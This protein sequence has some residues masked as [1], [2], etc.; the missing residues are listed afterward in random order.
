[1]TR[2]S[3]QNGCFFASAFSR[4]T[5]FSSG[6][7]NGYFYVI[8]WLRCVL[9]ASPWFLLYAPFMVLGTLTFLVSLLT[10]GYGAG[11][12]IAEH[13]TIVQAGG[14][15]YPSVDVFLPTCG[16][17][18][19]LLRNT[20]THVA[21]LRAAYR[22]RLT[23]Y[24]LDDGGRPELKAL[25]SGSGSRT[26]PGPTAGWFKKSGNLKYGFEISDGEFILLLDADF[27]PRTDLLDRDTALLRRVPRSRDRADAAVLP[28]GR[29]ADLGR[30]R[31]G[32]H[33]GAVLPVDP[34]GPGPQGRRD[35]RRKLRRLPPVRARARTA[36]CRSPSTRRT[37]TPASTCTGW[38][39]GCATCRSRCRPGTARTT[40][41]RS[42]TSSTAGARAR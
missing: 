22:G 21:A 7:G 9:L 3:R 35:L 5:V 36:A 6:G 41:W 29:R 8:Y 38:A 30:T 32:R 25:A 15:R 28:R 13:R 31:R 34:D 27:A 20:W 16:E 2:W 24:V 26:R 4:R 39:G 19:E 23:P 11:F 42:S 17:P 18:L 12:D 37:C 40:S 33:P 10:D 14:R 1:M